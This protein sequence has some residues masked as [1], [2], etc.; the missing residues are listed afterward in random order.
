MLRKISNKDFRRMLTLTGTVKV[1]NALENAKAFC[2]MNVKVS[3]IFR[4]SVPTSSKSRKRDT[5][6]PYRMKKMKIATPTR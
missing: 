4:R 1:V 6:P 3:D 5:T 2:A